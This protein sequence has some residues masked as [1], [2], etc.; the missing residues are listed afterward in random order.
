MQRWTHNRSLPH[1][2]GLLATTPNYAI[3]DDHDYGPNNSGWDFWNK[4]QA[5][6]AFTIF[7]GNPSAGLPDLPGIFTFFNYGDVNFY[8][9]D[10]RFYRNGQDSLEAFDREKDLL[11]KEQVDWLISSMK[12]WQGQSRSYPA[13]FNMVCIGNTVLSDNGLSENY[14]LYYN[15]EWQYLIDRIMA[16]GI[17]GVVFLSGDVHFSEVSVFEATG[18]GEPGRD[19]PGAGQPGEGNAGEG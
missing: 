1:L 13:N 3:W 11:G 19:R 9:L 12:Y 6:Q 17:D 10:N 5:T 15:K 18:G 7:N 8:L 2:R 4:E 16:E 14:A